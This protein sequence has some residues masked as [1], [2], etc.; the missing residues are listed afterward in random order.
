MDSSRPGVIIVTYNS[1]PYLEA[2]LKSLQN[3]TCAVRVIVVDNGSSDTS[4]AI[5][6][7]LDVEVLENKQNRGFSYAVNQGA[8][9]LFSEGAEYIICVNPDAVPDTKCIE[10]LI[11]TAKRTGAGIVQASVFLPDGKTV[12]S[13]GNVIHYSGIA[14]CPEFGNEVSCYQDVAVLAASGACMCISKKCYEDIGGLRDEFFLYMEDTDLSWRA[15]LGG[16]KVMLSC[17]ARC[18]HDYSLR[19]PG[20]KLALLDRNRLFMVLTNYSLKTLFLL[21]PLALVLE[22]GLLFWSM[23]KGYSILKVKGYGEIVWNIPLTLKKRKELVS[24]RRI[25]D[26]KIFSMMEMDLCVPGLHIPF[27]KTVN[28]FLRAYGSLLKKLL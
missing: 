9:K 20:W 6:R 14:Y 25:S 8:A 24:R 1:S 10:E 7:E 27:Q 18:I 13:L 19:L 28:V 17:N 4:V 12:N 15:W 16:Y 22:I 21:L 23:T 26:R 11:A 5:A 2:C 3:Q